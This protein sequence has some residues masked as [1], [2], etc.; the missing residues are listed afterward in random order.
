VAKPQWGQKRV[1]QQCGAGFY[2]L[3]RHPIVCP[4]CGATFDTE[5]FTRA[6]RR[7]APA[8]KV[9]PRELVKEEAEV[10]LEE[11]PEE[12]EEFEKVEE[13]AGEEEEEIIEDVSELGEDDD[14]TKVVESVDSNEG[15]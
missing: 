10:E 5:A 13:E 6:R 15:A 2:D 8:E 1:C 3:R 11:V 12:A 14:V 7:A 9:P 4:K